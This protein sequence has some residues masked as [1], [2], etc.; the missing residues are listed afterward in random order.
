MRE[1]LT[2]KVNGINDGLTIETDDN[3]TIGG[4]PTN[5]WI[6]FQG[7]GIHEG[8]RI[9]YDLRFQ[10][11]GIK[12]VGVNGVTHEALLAVLIDR[13]Q[14]FQAGEYKCRDNAIALM[15]L[16]DAMHRLKHRTESRMRRG[17]EGTHTK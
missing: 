13:L 3:L 15:H 12:E 9:D 7:S 17:V 4:A 8:K 1:I 10:D 11:G 6:H 16:E 14:G 2:H 5:Y